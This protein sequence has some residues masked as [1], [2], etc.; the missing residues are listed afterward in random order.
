M[1]RLL[2]TLAAAVL[3]AA[4]SGAPEGMAARYISADIENKVAMAMAGLA[5]ATGLISA[6]ISGPRNILAAGLSAWPIIAFVALAG[7]S[8]F[9]SPS[10]ADTLQS[11]IHLM[12]LVTAG[13][14]LAAF[15]NWR[16][17]LAGGALSILALGGLAV[18]LIP[19]GGLMSEIHPGAL[20][21]PWG[22]KNE[23]GMAIAFGA[24]CFI[25]LAFESRRFAWLAGLVALVPLLVLTQS[26]TSALAVAAG[27]IAMA[28]IELTRRTPARLL[29]MGWLTVVG[30]AS[31]AI[32]LTTNSGDLLAAAGKDTTLTGRSAIWPAVVERIEQ[33]PWL[34]HGYDAFWI[35]GSVSKMWL[36]EEIDFKAHNAH[37]GVLETLLGLGLVGLAL[38]TWL[39][40]RTMVLATIAAP[41]HLSVRR[42]GA[43]LM[44]AFLVISFSES[45]LSGPDG[46]IWF[47]F[48]AV[49]VKTAMRDARDQMPM[50]NMRLYAGRSLTLSSQALVAGAPSNP[51]RVS[52]FWI[53][54]PIKQSAAEKA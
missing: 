33:K 2:P 21:G 6:V 47:A 20:R 15:A 52:P 43:P 54:K 12:L 3:F 51:K 9:W 11:A 4:L 17:I 25:A 16:E 14:T 24:L 13:I 42:F 40:L 32:L 22:E 1:P 30:L 53:W 39:A 50:S 23:A 41:N 37:N 7:A 29:I 44:I 27:L 38:L 46:F 28:A 5:A 31:F 48:I 26:T 18:V 34:G 10:P 45:V 49:A 19:A 8:Q 35:E 36:W